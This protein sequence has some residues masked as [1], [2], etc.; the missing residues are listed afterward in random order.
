M[1]NA[2]FKVFWNNPIEL[3]TET[4]PQ[5]LQFNIPLG[6]IISDP[7][8]SSD[9][10]NY[11]TKPQTDAQI[12][13]AT[14]TKADKTYVD[15]S[16]ASQ[17]AVIATKADKSYVDSQD[18]LLAT[19]ISSRTT[20]AYVDQQDN[21]LSG[22]IDLKADSNVVTAALSTKADLVDGKIP[23]SQLPTMVDDVLTYNTQSLFPVV[24][25]DGKI[26]IAK[27]TNKSFRWTGI[28]YVELS[29]GVVLGE[30]SATAYRGDRGKIAYDHTFSTGN[31]HN[32]T[33]TD[34]PEGANLY[35]TDPRVRMTQLTGINITNTAQLAP[36]DYLIVGM[37]K[38]QGQINTKTSLTLGNTSTTA[39]A[40]NSTTS[41]ITEG[42]NLYYTDARVRATSLTGLSTATGGV[43]SATDT[44]LGSLGKLQNQITNSA[45][46]S[47][48]WVELSAIGTVASY[49][50]PYSI[51]LSRFQ[52]MLWI[53]GTF[54]V[55]TTVAVNSELFRITAQLY[56]PYAYSAAGTARLLQLLST[57]NSTSGSAKQIGISALG[58]IINT[59]QAATT[60]VIFEI[61]GSSVSTADGTMNIPP[62][63]IGTLVN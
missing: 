17:D 20:K 28:S 60:D 16:N 14:S 43:I 13:S 45:S 40:G 55:N 53:R 2:S 15:S 5:Q 36:T 34:I 4:S 47:P 54:N 46:G 6:A 33:T 26:Y 58:N 12:S 8:V 9:L 35:H 21:I 19:N 50:T 59:T 3:T 29:S 39:L 52:G 41:V 22:R 48:V 25:E 57:W 32:A 27:D 56:K 18:A 62:T 63:I 1:I 10:S 11:Y 37:G 24:G 44:V 42:T 61:K 30:T 31:P 7:S 23:E 51:Q 38:L 49:V